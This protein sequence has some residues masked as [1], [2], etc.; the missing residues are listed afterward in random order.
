MKQED[1]MERKPLAYS[2]GHLDRAGDRRADPAW[3]A[4]QLASPDSLLLPLWRDRCLITR[5]ES[6]PFSPTPR[7]LCAAAS[8][9]VLAAASEVVF[10]GLEDGL[11]VFVV[12]MSACEERQV[13][14]LVGG[15]AL[16]D[17]RH[18]CGA[19]PGRMAAMLA[20]ARGILHW[21]RHH[22]FCSLCG[23]RTASRHGGHMRICTSPGCAR[24]IFPRIEPAVIVLVESRPA[25]GEPRRCLLG[26]HKGAP[27]GVYS[28][29]AG[30]VEVGES[31][32]DAVHRELA[33]EA[34]VQ[35]H[36]IVYQA[37]QAWPFPS[38]LMVGFRAE[39]TSLTTRIDQDELVEVR[40]FTG[41]ELRALIAAERGPGERPMFNEDSIEGYL[42]KA[43]AAEAPPST[44]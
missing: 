41:A 20:Y 6:A 37:S 15:G 31:L 3:V 12:D 34:G 32:E 35:V 17:L 30:F 28:T 38:G 23:Q 39:A 11:A 1:D 8:S 44:R 5:A 33:E 27:E 21:N 26:R 13:L 43:W 9:S 36:K 16:V 25:A 2:G 14:D 22:P 7:V 24:P 18:I 4:E 10:L 42:I 19:L 29:L 40:W